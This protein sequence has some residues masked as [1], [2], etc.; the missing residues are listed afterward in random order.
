MRSALKVFAPKELAAALALVSHALNEDEPAFTLRQHKIAHICSGS[1][2]LAPLGTMGLVQ[3]VGA[4]D[5]P[6]IAK[7]LLHRVPNR[8]DVV[9]AHT[10]SVPQSFVGPARGFQ[11]LQIEENEQAV[12]GRAIHQLLQHVEEVQAAQLW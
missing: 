5:V 7:P 11:T 10:R 4:D 9:H 3:Q 1:C 8:L 2:P 6:P 12:I